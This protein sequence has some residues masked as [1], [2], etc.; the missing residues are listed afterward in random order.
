MNCLYPAQAPPCSCGAPGCG[1]G[2][3]HPAW[4]TSWFLLSIFFSQFKRIQ[5][6]NETDLM[7]CVQIFKAAKEMR[8]ILVKRAW[9]PPSILQDIPIY[10]FNKSPQ[11]VLLLL[12]SYADKG[13]ACV[14]E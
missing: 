2:A 1:A 4:G 3:L 12:L 6:F 9:H 14:G 5:P 10:E 13:L 8:L 11:L 7:N